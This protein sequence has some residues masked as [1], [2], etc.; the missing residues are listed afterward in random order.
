MHFCLSGPITAAFH[1]RLK[2]PIVDVESMLAYTLAFSLRL[3]EIGIERSIE[4]TM[5]FDVP[6]NPAL[7]SHIAVVR[8]GG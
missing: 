6:S 8:K 7:N 2:Q 4:P 1:R 3:P 5:L